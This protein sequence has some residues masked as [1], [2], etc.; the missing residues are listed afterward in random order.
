MGLFVKSILLTI[1]TTVGISSLVGAIEPTQEKLSI[2]TFKSRAL[3]G[4]ALDDLNAKKPVVIMIPGSG[5]N[6]PEGMVEP[7]VTLDHKYHSILNDLSTPLRKAGF[8]T[9][10]L[11]KPGVEFFDPAH[12][13]TQF[14]DLDLLKNL[15]WQGYIDNV[16]AAVAYVK[17]RSD[18]DSNHIF[19]LG[20]SE[21]TQV[22]VDFA[23]NHP[24]ISGLILLGFM[25]EDMKTEL[26]WQLYRRVIDTFI[27]PDVDK[28]QDGYVSKEEVARWPGVFFGLAADQER[29]SL[30]EIEQLLRADPQNQAL[31]NAAKQSASLAGVFER[32]SI[33][34]KVL[35]LKMPIFVM[36]GSL[37]V[38]TRPE[39]ALKLKNLASAAGRSNIHVK[40]IPGFGHGFSA[41]RPPRSHQLL[42]LTVGPVDS[43]FQNILF[44]LGKDIRSYFFFIQ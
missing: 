41:P 17:T 13:H 11:G 23:Q 40:I 44:N 7:T 34:D 43:S 39:E 16:A 27:I 6:G 19:L 33:Y 38:Q 5:P 18:V 29:I 10:Q 4:A 1:I 14:Y 9:L 22:A 20:H 30:A 26:G 8:H 24:H 32:G 42:D 25:G 31:F 36:T 2:G 15:R 12:P 3:F 35:S 37:D 28:N 21:G